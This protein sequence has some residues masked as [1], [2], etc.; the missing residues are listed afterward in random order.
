M[1]GRPWILVAVVVAVF[2][3][4]AFTTW[5]LDGPEEEEETDPFHMTL[6]LSGVEANITDAN[7]TDVAIWVAVASGEPHPLWEDLRVTLGEVEGSPVLR[8]PNLVIDDLDDDGGVSEG[9]LLF[10][11]GL[12]GSVAEG[13][14]ALWEDGR[15]IAKVEI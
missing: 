3:M 5:W 4:L 6:L 11:F 15:L 8:P 1:A 14:I 10:V 7:L 9:D 2:T 12:E 13:S